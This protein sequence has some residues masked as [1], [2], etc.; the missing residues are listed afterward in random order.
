[1]SVSCL[2]VAA[3][4]FVHITVWGNDALCKRHL[5]FNYTNIHFLLVFCVTGEL[6][7]FK[8]VVAN[9]LPGIKLIEVRILK[10]IG[11]SWCDSIPR[12][13]LMSVFMIISLSKDYIE[14]LC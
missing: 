13:F 7:L 1:V 2:G 9:I 12:M 14:F 5:H 6:V 4:T 8:S 3:L 11:Q 10:R